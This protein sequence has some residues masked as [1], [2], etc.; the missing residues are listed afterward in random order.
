MKHPSRGLV[1][2]LVSVTIMGP[3]QGCCTV[4][5][6]KLVSMKIEKAM[7]QSCWI[8]ILI[9]ISISLETTMFC[10]PGDIYCESPNMGARKKFQF[11]ERAIHFFLTTEEFLQLRALAKIQ[12]D[13][14]CADDKWHSLVFFKYIY[15]FIY[16]CTYK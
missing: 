10:G 5:N 14:L 4:K 11:S 16:I 13:C 7:V 6:L 1:S 8:V 15:L 2:P 9:C 12:P 3:F